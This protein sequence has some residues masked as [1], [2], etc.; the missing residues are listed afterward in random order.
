M[1]FKCLKFGAYLGASVGL[2]PVKEFGHGF[3]QFSLL[4]FSGIWTIILVVLNMVA[5]QTAVCIVLLLS[6]LLSSVYSELGAKVISALSQ[7]YLCLVYSIYFLWLFALPRF[8]EAWKALSLYD[9]RYSVPTNRKTKATAIAGTVIQAALFCFEC[10]LNCIAFKQN[11][12]LLQK[13]PATADK[14]AMGSMVARNFNPVVTSWIAS[15][16]MSLCQVGTGLA[17]LLALF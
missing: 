12:L 16:H 14:F 2:F 5:A 1:E 6:E 10:I 17:V 9:T 3:F 8:L 7:V 13:S 15:F 4:S 11:V